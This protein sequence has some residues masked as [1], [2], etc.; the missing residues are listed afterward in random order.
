MARLIIAVLFVSAALC[1]PALAA[2]ERDTIQTVVDSGSIIVLRSGKVFQVAALDKLNS[3]LWL[4]TEDVLACDDSITNI[5]ENGE[6]VAAR[7]LN[8]NRAA[9]IDGPSTSVPAHSAFAPISPAESLARGN[10]AAQALTDTARRNAAYRALQKTYG[11]VAG[12]PDAATKLQEYRFNVEANKLKLQLLRSENE[13]LGQRQRAA[14]QSGSSETSAPNQSF[15]R[16][17]IWE[18]TASD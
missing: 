11:D 1:R 18:A 17:D 5:D 16:Y 3:S 4:A 14:T 10:A 7:L 6:R 9:L 2:C 8:P 13:R 15:R 12:D